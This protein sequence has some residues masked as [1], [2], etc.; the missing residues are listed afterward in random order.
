MAP[1]L[2]DNINVCTC[3]CTQSWKISAYVN[4]VAMLLRSDIIG[5]IKVILLPLS[6]CSLKL[7]HRE[8]VSAL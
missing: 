5:C 8:V 3:T 4:K 1:I 6:L 7:K 2:H